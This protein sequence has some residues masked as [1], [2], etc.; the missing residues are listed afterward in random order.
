MQAIC[1]PLDIVRISFTSKGNEL[2]FPWS[3]L[4]IEGTFLLPQD[5]WTELFLI[6]NVYLNSTATVIYFFMNYIF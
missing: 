1:L 3:L 2:S 4:K 6:S 5:F